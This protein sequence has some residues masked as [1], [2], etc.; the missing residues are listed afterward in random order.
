VYLGVR[1]A[2]AAV[3]D[4]GEVVAQ[5]VH[6]AVER[7]AIRV[8]VEVIFHDEVAQPG[9]VE[10]QV[11]DGELR[12]L[13]V[14]LDAVRLDA[15]Q[16]RGEGVGVGRHPFPPVLRHRG[17]AVAVARRPGQV[18]IDAAAA[19]GDGGLV[20]VRG[21]AVTGEVFGQ[22]GAV[23][24]FGFVAREGA[25]GAGEGDREGADVGP[26]VQPPLAGDGFDGPALAVARALDDLAQHG[27]VGGAR[28][29]DEL[30]VLGGK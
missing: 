1:A 6:A 17:M 4:V 27:F 16:H 11:E 24:G 25:P 18:E 10:P 12:A 8:K 7:R 26:G 14:E 28:A 15:G 29:H 9:Q 19:G 21:D 2:I 22:Q 3:V 30:A 5:V 20:D 13:D 23:V